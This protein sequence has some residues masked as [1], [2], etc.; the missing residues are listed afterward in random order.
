MTRQTGNL[1][2]TTP[3]GGDP[4]CNCGTVYKLTPGS[5]GHWNE[6]VLYRFTG[7]ADG[8]IPE[9]S[10]AIDAAGNLYGT[11]FFGG[12]PGCYLNGGCG[13]VFEITP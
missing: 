6:T 3:Y 13:V 11:T 10:L 5:G 4:A 1:Y 2:G 7:G 9:S 8:I 12:N